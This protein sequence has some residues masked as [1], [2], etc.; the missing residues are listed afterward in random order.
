[1]NLVKLQDQFGGPLFF[2]FFF[3]LESSWDSRISVICVAQL[4]QLNISHIS[5]ICSDQLNWKSE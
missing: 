5:K 2:F 1:M 3:S 4:Q